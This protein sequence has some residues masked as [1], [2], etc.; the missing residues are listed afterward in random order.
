MVDL[1]K[2]SQDS[3]LPARVESLYPAYKAIHD[4]V[5]SQP[6]LVFKIRQAFF[7]VMNY[8]YWQIDGA[9]VIPI[10]VCL[11]FNGSSIQNNASNI[12]EE[13]ENSTTCWEFQW[14]NSLLMNLIPGDILL[15]MD[16]IFTAILYS[17]IVESYD[18]RRL[19]LYIHLNGNLLEKYSSL[20][21]YEQA[22]ALFFCHVSHKNND[23]VYL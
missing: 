8:R 18:N 20:E 22:L 10:D 6:K 14:T 17:N 5:W 16:P 9:E 13:A 21:V 19:Y 3:T 1:A 2:G 15:A 11:Q 7:P 4:T 23:I 12:R